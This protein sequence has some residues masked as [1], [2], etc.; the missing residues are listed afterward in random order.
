MENYSHFVYAYQ[1]FDYVLIFA[2]LFLGKIGP[3]LYFIETAIIMILQEING[4]AFYQA[5][6]YDLGENSMLYARRTAMLGVCLALL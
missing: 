4:P 3:I 5:I 2:I 1:M 6:V